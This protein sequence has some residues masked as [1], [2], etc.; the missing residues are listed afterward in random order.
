MQ[1]GKLYIVATPIGNLSDMT[2]RA[3][4]VLKSVAF[5]LSE[6]T[7][8]SKK[9]L[10]RYEIPTQLISYRDQNHERVIGKVL[11]KLDMGLDL[12]LIS[13]AGTPLISDPGFKLV[14]DLREKGYD[15]VS[16]PGASA[17]IAALSVSGLPT[18]RFV[19]LGFLPKSDERRRK[20]LE[21]YVN[22]ENTIVIYESPQRLTRLLEL[23]LNEF[24]D[25]DVYLAK[26]ISKMRE[27]SFSGKISDVLEQ[28]EERKFDENPHGEFV[29]VSR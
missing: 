8:E 16:I 12:A 14:R 18:D 20:L 19:F 28:L 11:E 24:R 29:C 9:L 10:D 27:E 3:I 26:D 13:D 1:K 6:D 5:V 22:L 7:R 17:V 21:Q 25:M 2:L 23:I 4:E 15:V